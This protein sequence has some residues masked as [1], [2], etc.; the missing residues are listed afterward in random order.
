MQG[1]ELSLATVDVAAPSSRLLL[2]GYGVRLAT[3]DAFEL[4][5]SHR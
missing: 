2:A 5:L 3:Y 4:Q 1:G